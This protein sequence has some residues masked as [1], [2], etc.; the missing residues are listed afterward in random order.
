VDA[1]QTRRLPSSAS[2]TG[3]NAHSGQAE[4]KPPCGPFHWTATL[5]VA[6]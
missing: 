2:L 5:P 6:Y 1:T 4:E 3:L